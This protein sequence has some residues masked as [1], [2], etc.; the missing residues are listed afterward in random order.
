MGN[1]IIREKRLQIETS[2]VSVGPARILLRPFQLIVWATLQR[3][4]QSEPAPGAVWL[5]CVVDTGFNGTFCIAHELAG[6]L[7]ASLQEKLR[8]RTRP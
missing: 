1:S 6:A 4:G 5:P 8:S 2:I 7:I 3:R